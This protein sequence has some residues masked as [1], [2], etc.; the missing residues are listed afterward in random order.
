MCVLSA[1]VS[2]VEST[3]SSQGLRR[4]A[5]MNL[6]DIDV[7]SS[8]MLLIRCCAQHPLQQPGWSNQVLSGYT[9][10]CPQLVVCEPL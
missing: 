1:I 7:A 4:G 10:W 6:L 8:N 3:Y 5:P 2:A 9:K